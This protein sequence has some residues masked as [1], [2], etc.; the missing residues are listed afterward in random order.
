MHLSSS[1][2]HNKIP[3]REGKE[4]GEFVVRSSAIALESLGAVK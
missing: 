2:S 1:S 4:E 3:C